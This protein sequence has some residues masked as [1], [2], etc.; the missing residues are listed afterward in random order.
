MRL[1]EKI[2]R[3]RTGIQI[4]GRTKEDVLEMNKKRHIMRVPLSL[5]MKIKM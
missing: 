5:A 1:W 3:C 2:T 4:S